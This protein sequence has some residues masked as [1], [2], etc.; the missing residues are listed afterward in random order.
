MKRTN[1][2]ICNWLKKHLHKNILKSYKIGCLKHTNKNQHTSDYILM[3]WK[4]G[5][6]I[7]LI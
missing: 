1:L 3:F 4:C 6:K 2:L 7:V 5:N